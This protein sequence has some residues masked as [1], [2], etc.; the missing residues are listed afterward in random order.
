MLALSTFKSPEFDDFQEPKAWMND[1]FPEET[2]DILCLY[3][4]QDKT[5]GKLLFIS[6][7]FTNYSRSYIIK[8]CFLSSI[9]DLSIILI[10]VIK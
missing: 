9:P 1:G 6:L 2:G 7:S 10:Y 3:L 8:K 4:H 5:K